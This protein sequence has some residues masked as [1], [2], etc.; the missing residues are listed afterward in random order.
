MGLG[1]TAWRGLSRGGTHI[2][3]VLRERRRQRG[4]VGHRFV[5]AGVRGSVKAPIRMAVGQNIS[6][7]SGIL[8]APASEEP[9][10]PPPSRFGR[11]RACTLILVYVLMVVH[12]THWM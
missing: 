4:F 12:I 3:D 11:W 6:P 7:A 2:G 9:S 1:A 8:D 5:S 10:I